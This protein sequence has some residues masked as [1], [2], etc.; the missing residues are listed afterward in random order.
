[1]PKTEHVSP[2]PPQGCSL[3]GRRTRKHK[4]RA[5]SREEKL[6]GGNPRGG[7][8]GGTDGSGGLREGVEG[9]GGDKV[10]KSTAGGMRLGGIGSDV[11]VAD[12]DGC[13]KTGGIVGGVVGLSGETGRA[14]EECSHAASR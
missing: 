6:S 5:E 8:D 10:H 14:R 7:V 12:G 9:N 1:M 3:I 11:G 4:N 2:K 13:G